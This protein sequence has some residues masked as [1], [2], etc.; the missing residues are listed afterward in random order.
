MENQI[1]VTYQEN[2]GD[3]LK[4]VLIDDKLHWSLT[5]NQFVFVNNF[6]NRVLIENVLSFN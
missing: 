2:N 4:G 6:A 1:T 3:I 5:G